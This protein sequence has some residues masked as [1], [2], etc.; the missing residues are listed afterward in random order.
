MRCTAMFTVWG[1][2]VGACWLVAGCCA[3]VPVDRI[4]VAKSNDGYSVAVDDCPGHLETDVSSIKVEKLPERRVVCEVEGK[5]DGPWMYGR[6]LRGARASP[7]PCEP[8]GAGSVYRVTTKRGY[9]VVQIDM[10]GNPEVIDSN[11]QK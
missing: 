10:S 4:Q 5:V 1:A 8:L 7:R 9:L 6:D 2:S 11:C 3:A